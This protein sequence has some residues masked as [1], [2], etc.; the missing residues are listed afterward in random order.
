MPR[1][2]QVSMRLVRGLSGFLSSQFRGIGTH[3]EL[4]L[5]PQCSS[6]VLTWISGFLWSFNRGVRP[7]F[8]W[9]HGTLLSSRDVK[10]VSGF[11][12][13]RHWVLGLSLEVPKGFPLLFMVLVDTRVT[14]EPMQGNQDHLE[15]MQTLGSF[16]MEAQSLAMGSSFQVRPASS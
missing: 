16:L 8:M 14:V 15:W 5:E 3:L 2:S 6:A 4:R 9:R 7:H 11:L 12:S 10:G 1:E 13:T